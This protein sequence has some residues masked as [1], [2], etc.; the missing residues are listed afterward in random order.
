MFEDPI[1][2][3]RLTE[4]NFVVVTLNFPDESKSEGAIAVGPLGTAT[5]HIKRDGRTT[6]SLSQYASALVHDNE[7]TF[8]EAG[9]RVRHKPTAALPES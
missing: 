6:T 3:V 8:R 2:N 9:L 5:Y 1:E 7:K 4:D